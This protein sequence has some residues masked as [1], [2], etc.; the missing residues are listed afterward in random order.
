MTALQTTDQ[1]GVATPAEWR[2]GDM[3]I[4]PPPKTQ[5]DA[6]K[7]MDEGFELK[8]WWFAKKKL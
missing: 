4:V 7:R 8:D 5:A 6:E 1:N 3:C 2:A